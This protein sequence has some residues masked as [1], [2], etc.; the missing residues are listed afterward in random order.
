M[1]EGR[2]HLAAG[3]ACR[4]DYPGSNNKHAHPTLKELKHPQ[5]TLECDSALRWE[6]VP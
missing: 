1:S 5:V 4:R 6:S 2:F 3:A